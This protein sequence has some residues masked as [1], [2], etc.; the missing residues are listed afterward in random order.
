VGL[1]CL[2]IIIPVV[3]MMIICVWWCEPLQLPMCCT[4]FGSKYRCVLA[5]VHPKVEEGSAAMA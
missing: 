4:I 5:L 1:R 3:H 2:G